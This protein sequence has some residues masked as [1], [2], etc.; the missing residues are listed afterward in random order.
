MSALTRYTQQLF[1]SSAGSNQMA[2]Y[3]SLA[4]GSPN[5]YNGTTITPAIIQTLSEYLEGWFGAVVGLNS[6]AIE[7][8]NALCYLFSYQIAYLLERGIPEWDVGTTYF[9]GDIVQSAGV[10]YASITN[11]NVGNAVTDG[12]NWFTATD[13]GTLTVNSLPFT[14]GM[15]L[16]ANKSLT[17]PNME[18]GNGQT[19]VVPNSANLIGITQITV[20]GTGVLTATG[21]GIIRVI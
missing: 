8:M 10:R 16:P 20:S 7:D 18:I 17:W 11:T 3:G 12:A 15:T 9:I 4:A 2:E 19:V 21:S 14:A 6:P 1:G 5:R 13:P